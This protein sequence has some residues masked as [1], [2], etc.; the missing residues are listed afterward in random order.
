M[1]QRLSFTFQLLAVAISLA[2]VFSGCRGYSSKEPPFHVNP[3]MYTQEKGKAYRESDF[4]EDGQDM[5]KPIEGTVARGQLKEDSHFYRGKVDG[6]DARSFPKELE[7]NEGFIKRGQQVYMRTCAVCH[8][9]IGDGQ[10][11]VGKRLLV[12]PTSF[13]SEYMYGLPPGHFFDAI[14]NGIRTMQSY[15]HLIKEI[16][17]WAVTSYIRILQ[18]SQDVDGGWIERSAP[19]WQQR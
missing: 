19:L 10:G 1:N 13:H 17:R 9:A 16:D 12:K 11:L 3:N 6:K 4:F 2:V 18:I 8:S 15:G 14:T 7:I 5:R